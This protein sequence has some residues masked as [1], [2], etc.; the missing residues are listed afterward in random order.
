MTKR[1]QIFL[2]LVIL[3]ST[4]GTASKHVGRAGSVLGGRLDLDVGGAHLMESF[5]DDAMGEFGAVAVAAE[6]AEVEAGQAGGDDLF[7][8]IG[9]AVVGKVA[10]AAEDALL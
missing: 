8:E 4:L 1:C 2:S 10:V 7:G 5:G 3:D 9:R 6:M